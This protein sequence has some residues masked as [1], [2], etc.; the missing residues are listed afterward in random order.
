VARRPL[1]HH[2]LQLNDPAASGGAGT[3]INAYFIET[4][5]RKYIQVGFQGLS[6]TISTSVLGALAPGVTSAATTAV[7]DTTGH[8]VNYQSATT[9]SAVAGWTSF[10]QNTVQRQLLFDLTWVVKTGAAAADVANCTIWVAVQGVSGTVNTTST[11]DMVG[12]RF[13]TAVPDTNWMCVSTDSANNATTTDSGVAVTADTRY[14]FRMRFTDI[15]TLE[16]YINGALVAT[17]TSAGN[18]PTSATGLG[19]EAYTINNSAGTAR[20]IRIMQMKGTLL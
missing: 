20:S 1:F 17:H 6:T 18:L 12:F 7:Q 2:K 16:F 3:A 13:R 15:N 10:T 5:A 4:D 11:A 19:F 9:L 14:V 8:Y